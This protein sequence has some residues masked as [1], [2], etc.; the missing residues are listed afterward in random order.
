MQSQTRS[1]IFSRRVEA[2]TTSKGSNLLG[3]LLG[4]HEG[5][6]GSEEPKGLTEASG[7]REV[8]NDA[9]GYGVQVQPPNLP[10]GTPYWQAV[11]IHHRT[12]EENGGNHHIYLD[13]NDGAAGSEQYG[14]RLNGARLRVTWDGGEQVVTVD[15]PVNEPGTNF[16]M[17]KWQVCAVACL[18]LPGQE[19]PS[20]RVTGL[21]TGHPDEAPGNTLFHHSF[22]V[23]FVKAQAAEQVY[24]D[25]VIYGV[26]NNASGRIAILFRDGQEAA[27]KSLTADETFRFPGLGAGEYVLAVED[28]DFKSAVTRVN[29]RD[30][31]M[32]DLTLVLRQ[33]VISGKTR[34][35]SGRT[36]VLLKG[37]AELATQAVAPEETYRFTGLEAGAYR[38]TLQGT[39]V[40]SDILNLNGAN[41][42]TADLAAPAQGRAIEHYVLFGPN[43]KP[44]TRAAL[45]LALDYILAFKATFGFSVAEAQ[46]A[47]SVTI[48]GAEED[49][50]METEKQLITAGTTVQRVTG[51]VE[52]VAASLGARI[53]SGRAFG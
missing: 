10:A 15:K 22:H 51:T 45:L 4:R 37:T 16:P 5:Q 6:P 38:V 33:S 44:H 53:A 9:T 28:T 42:A 8:A 39:Q 35:G 24:T 20:D 27:R 36:V 11:R 40:S 17:W 30:Q 48:V 7:P 32:L 29:G 50:N 14:S 43:D 12:P 26:I 34:G 46:S 2:M 19:L 25:S 23:T 47:A 49:V 1:R 21:H 18:G 52:E 31:V 41:A 3:R 13:V